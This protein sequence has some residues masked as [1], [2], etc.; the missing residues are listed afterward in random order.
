M[1]MCV[2]T[3]SVEEISLDVSLCVCGLSMSMSI[4]MN[5][6]INNMAIK[7]NI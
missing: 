3:C 5:T 2:E 4:I 1:S 6:N 7:Y